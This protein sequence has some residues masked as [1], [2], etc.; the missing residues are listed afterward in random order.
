MLTLILWRSLRLNTAKLPMQYLQTLS[1]LGAQERVQLHVGMP[2]QKEP[3]KRSKGWPFYVQW[4]ERLP[5]ECTFTSNWSAMQLACHKLYI[6][7]SGNET[8]RWNHEH[9]QP[10]WATWVNYYGQ[11]HLGSGRCVRWHL[12]QVGMLDVT[13]MHALAMAAGICAQTNG[14]KGHACGKADS[15]CFLW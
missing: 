2:R 11:P 4:L 9:A 10:P 6:L 13:Y 8:R 14:C 7:V 3:T 5:L 15:T 12:D 1:G